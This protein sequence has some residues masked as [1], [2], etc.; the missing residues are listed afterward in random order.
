MLRKLFCVC[1]LTGAVLLAACGGGSG[2][3]TTST[4]MVSVPNVVGLS[5]A[6]ATSSLTTAGLILGSVTGQASTTVPAG[7]V[8]SESPA[9]G[10]SVAQGSAVSLVATWP[11]LNLHIHAAGHRRFGA[12]GASE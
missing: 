3:S 11:R 12:G 8:I 6:S 9:A 2:A 4:P 1:G 7:D 10:S 5:Q